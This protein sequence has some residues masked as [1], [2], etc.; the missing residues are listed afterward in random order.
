MRD[1]DSRL[2]QHAVRQARTAR[3]RRARQRGAIFVE[4][5]IVISFFILALIGLMYFRSL[6]TK[7]LQAMWLARSTALVYSMGAC[8]TAD[9]EP[10]RWI[11]SDIGSLNPPQE[12]QS[13]TEPAGSG[14]SGTPQDQTTESKA[15]L[16]SGHLGSLS[17]DGTKILNEITVATFSGEARVTKYH[18][19]SDTRK[20]IFSKEVSS[21]SYI[22]CGEEVRDGNQFEGM[23]D[24]ITGLLGLP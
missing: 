24:W 17:S 10:D 13:D 1:T 19:A 21:K 14:A 9:N 8:K 22:S 11:D 15:V 18:A 20:P 5:V 2:P 7:K 4:A 23:V 16:E 12:P 6:Y 3:T